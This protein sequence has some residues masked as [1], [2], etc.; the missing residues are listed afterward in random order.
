[1]FGSSFGKWKKTNKPNNNIN[2]HTLNFKSF[3]SHLECQWPVLRLAILEKV[4]CICAQ[5]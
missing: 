3:S 1:M 2:K 5:I 4:I